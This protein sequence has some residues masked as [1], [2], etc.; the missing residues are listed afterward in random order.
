M[1]KKRVTWIAWLGYFKIIQIRTEESLC[2]VKDKTRW[3]KMV[4]ERFKE[5]VLKVLHMTCRDG[6][7]QIFNRW[8]SIRLNAIDENNSSKWKS[9]IRQIYSSIL[10]YWSKIED[11][12]RRL[13]QVSTYFSMRGTYIFI[14]LLLNYCTLRSQS[15]FRELQIIPEFFVIC[16]AW[17]HNWRGCFFAKCT[18]RSQ[19]SQW[20]I[21]SWMKTMV[22]FARFYRAGNWKIC[23]R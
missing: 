18:A 11:V 20:T 22:R 6:G 17:S 4:S 19:S 5:Q 1:F 21:H 13:Q 3:C 9:C 10:T 12:S 7:S 8:I 16:R 15:P 23:R 14:G 2:L